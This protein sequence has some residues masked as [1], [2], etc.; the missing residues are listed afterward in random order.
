MKRGLLTLALLAAA[1]MLATAQESLESR[2]AKMEASFVT[3]STDLAQVK[4]DVAAI[5]A[6]VFKVPVATNL[7]PANGAPATATGTNY[8]NT[9]VTCGPG[10]CTVSTAAG[11][12]PPPRRGFFGRL[13]ARRAS[14]GGCQ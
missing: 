7:Y 1:P 2:I 5:K 13:Q 6:Q 3:T 14:A 4:A 10:G 12:S 9:T 11:S 8:G